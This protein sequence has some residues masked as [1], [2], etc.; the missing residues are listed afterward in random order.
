M[1]SNDRG[2]KNVIIYNESGVTLGDVT[3][4]FVT[5]MVDTA[6]ATYS[7]SAVAFAAATTPTDVFTIIGS[8]TKT[9]RV[10][11]VAVTGTQTTGA[12]RDILLIKRSAA[13]TGGTSATATA[14]PH[15]SLSAAATA[16][17]KS[18]TANP[19]GLGAVV[20]TI[21][22]EK[23]FI[24]ATTAVSGEL[25]ADYGPRYGQSIVLRGAAETLAVNLNSVTSTGNSITIC[26][27]WTEE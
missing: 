24:G 4:P 18:Y 12:M 23:I 5:Y 25:I 21:R 16:A 6:K 27:E 10:I 19:S 14:V 7:A 26:V 15:D 13:N 8:G 17:V 2:S 11:R 22:A 3:T 1:A 20:G 9:V